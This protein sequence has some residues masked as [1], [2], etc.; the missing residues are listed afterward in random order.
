MMKK[1]HGALKNFVSIMPVFH[2]DE[3]GQE[4]TLVMAGDFNADELYKANNLVHD[5]I[6]RDV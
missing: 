6:K 5:H 3:R 2:P 4:D 1:Q